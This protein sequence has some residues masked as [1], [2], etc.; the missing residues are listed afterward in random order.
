MSQVTQMQDSFSPVPVEN[1]GLDDASFDRQ[2]SPVLNEMRVL[3]VDD[4]AIDRLAVIRELRAWEGKVHT[5]EAST[6]NAAL[7]HYAHENFDVVLLDFRLP[8]MDGLEVLRLMN[9]R[10]RGSTAIIMV[11]GL[12]DDAVSLSCIEAGAQDFLLKNEITTKRLVRSVIH[13]RIRHNMELELMRSLERVR[14]LSE[15]DTLTGLYNRKSFD[16]ILREMVPRALRANVP[17]ALLL[18]D[19]DDF[20]RIND[21]YGH[22]CGDG[23]LQQI[24]TRLEQLVRA[25]DVLFRLGGDEFA[26]IA[27]YDHEGDSVHL[28]A[29]RLIRAIAAPVQQGGTQ[30]SATASI[31]IAVLPNNASH[32]DELLKC[33]DLAM[34]RAKK[35]GRN[36]VRYY[37]EDLQQQLVRWVET[38][39]DLRRSLDSCGFQVFYQPQVCSVHGDIIG[40][41]ALMRWQHPVRGL[42][43]PGEFLDV[44]EGTGLIAPIG[45]MVIERACFDFMR[46]VMASSDVRLSVNISAAQ[47]RSDHFVDWFR[48]LLERSKLLPER[49]EI[50]ITESMLIDN[51]EQS[52]SK[53]E[54][55]SSMGVSIA[56][57]DFGTGYSSLSY[58]KVLPISTLKVDKSFLE[59]VPSKEK[60]T[61][62]LGALISLAH[63]MDYGVVVEGIENIEQA[64]KCRELRA[65]LLQ[66]YYYARPMPFQ[67][68]EDIVM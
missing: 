35:S 20:K 32:A 5:V 23:L 10:R 55:L 57:D 30:L 54:E 36:C 3:V 45:D 4:D 29:E 19:L 16:R 9:A 21:A 46:G 26:L 22:E 25:G 41:E 24:S 8:D 50:E 2:R 28:L 47:L 38:E 39:R 40:A 52:H 68:F 65:E 59:A 43:P 15:R 53:V 34:Y 56:L 48:D 49:L 67:F 31:G 12:D 27:T 14:D 18:L 13:A 6:A 64:E 58:L 61:R 66:G 11:S 63:E 44:A 1:G 51:L 7:E 62:M 42:L 37:S 17:L 33:A 60:D